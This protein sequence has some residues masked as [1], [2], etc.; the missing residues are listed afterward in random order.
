MLCLMNLSEMRGAAAGSF[1]AC[2]C[3]M[4]KL[5]KRIACPSLNPTVRWQGNLHRGM[6]RP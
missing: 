4:P 1:L 2:V 3:M 6:L 5:L